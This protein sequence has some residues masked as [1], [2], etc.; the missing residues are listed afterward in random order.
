MRLR[1]IAFGTLLIAVVALAGCLFPS[2]PRAEFSYTPKSG[3]PPLEVSF[4]AG[5]S[6]S[7]NGIIVAYDWDFGD[8]TTG[9][10]KE[11]KHKF[12]E[13]GIYKVTLTVT[14]DAGKEGTVYH[15]VQA[16]SLPPHAAFTYSPYMT[17]T[18][19]PVEFDA[20]D[21]YDPDGE[22]VSYTWDFGDGTTGVGEYTEHIYTSAGGSGTQ[23]PVTLTVVDDDGVQN[24]ITKY[25]HVIGCDSCGG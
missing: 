14:D 6:S 20:S 17:P 10:G 25:V 13:K 19:Q 3:Y 24:S 2:L 18:N 8:G 15:N 12:T 23:Y 5:A 11:I 4:N 7:P 1:F 16:L 21:S 9:T 22:I